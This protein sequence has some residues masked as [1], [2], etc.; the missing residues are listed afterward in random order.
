MKRP[1]LIAKTPPAFGASRID[2]IDLCVKDDQIGVA[3]F[4][5]LGALEPRPAL[6]RPRMPDSGQAE[7][8]SPAVVIRHR[9]PSLRGREDSTTGVRSW[10][11]R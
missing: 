10:T 3:S 8:F 1:A 2:G 11:W 6:T 9:S 5:S 4:G 7:E